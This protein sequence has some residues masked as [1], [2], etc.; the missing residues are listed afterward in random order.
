MKENKKQE[1]KIPLQ[2]K[3]S[4][5]G[6]RTSKRPKGLPP[7]AP[8]QRV[9]PPMPQSNRNMPNTKI[10]P[11]PSPQKEPSREIQSRKGARG[12]RISEGQKKKRKNPKTT[13]AALAE[14]KS[15]R[16]PMYR[17]HSREQTNPMEPKR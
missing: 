14:P 3:S 1:K 6:D 4:E 17:L 8:Q 5:K 2:K 11:S 13:E 10:S 12:H 7:T 16:Y 9:V 15:N